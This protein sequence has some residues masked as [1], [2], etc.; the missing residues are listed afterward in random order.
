MQDNSAQVYD[1]SAWLQGNVAAVDY[2]LV[3]IEK[4]YIE[5]A[6]IESKHAK[7]AMQASVENS[8]GSEMQVWKCEWGG[9]HLISPVLSPLY[10]HR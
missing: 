10:L 5:W 2:A 3:L 9:R 6:V 1:Y 7:Y 8:D 4:F